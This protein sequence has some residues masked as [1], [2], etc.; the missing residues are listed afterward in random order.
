MR[1]KKQLVDDEKE[2][3]SYKNEYKPDRNINKINHRSTE[4]E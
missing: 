3:K 1:P 4:D 2:R